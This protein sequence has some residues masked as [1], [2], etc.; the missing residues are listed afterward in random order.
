M[1]I[2]HSW[3]QLSEF[4]DY[5]WYDFVGNIGVFLLIASYWALQMEY[6]NPKGFFY[7][8]INLWV[9]ILLSVNLYHRPNLSSIIIEVFWAIISLYGLIKA[10]KSRS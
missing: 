8:F 5:A 10:L 1:D 3:S 7:S 4:Y 6:L 2:W 9:A